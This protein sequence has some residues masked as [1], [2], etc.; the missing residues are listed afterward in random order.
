ML[1]LPPILVWLS[2]GGFIVCLRLQWLE[3]N[4]DGES[5]LGK[6]QSM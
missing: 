2:K 4:M 1:R 6:V 5:G 3:G